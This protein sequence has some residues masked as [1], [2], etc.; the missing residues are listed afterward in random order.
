MLFSIIIPAYNV[1]SYVEDCL[2][3]VQESLKHFIQP[4][5][6]EIIVIDD[7]STDQTG[8]KLLQRVPGIH[9][10]SLNLNQGASVARNAG[11]RQASGEYVIFLDAD[12]RP[13]SD[14][15]SII[16]DTVRSRPHDD[17]IV[18]AMDLIDTQEQ[19]IGSFYGD[20]VLIDVPAQ[21]NS[22]SEALLLNFLDNFSVVKRSVFQ[23]LQ[24]DEHQKTLED[25]D[26]WIR[27]LFEHYGRIS[28]QPQICR[29]RANSQTSQHAGSDPIALDAT[30]R[31]YAKILLL[32]KNN[33]IPSQ[34]VAKAYEV[35]HQLSVALSQSSSYD[36][37]RQKG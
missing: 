6:V 16:H 29:I 28:F 19:I 37:W 24:Y 27:L 3:S 1:E 13:T 32:R 9:V 17:A 11:V 2:D 35:L 30:I 25:W 14:S 23:V 34:I 22:G 21:L 18:L 4:Q 15:L 5:E 33:P 26:L 12:N 7:G 31:I 20:K 36:N 8:E 10:I